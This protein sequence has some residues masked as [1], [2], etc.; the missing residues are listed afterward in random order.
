MVNN[1]DNQG[2]YSLAIGQI[3]SF[4]LGESL[5]TLVALP[6]LKMHFFNKSFF[7]IWQGKIIQYLSYG[8]LAL[9]AIMV[10]IVVI[11]KKIC[12]RAKNT[13]KKGKK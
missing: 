8:L 3:E 6:A 2:K 4:P 7:A 12:H 11:I 13:H 9:I 10:I 1:K 5:K